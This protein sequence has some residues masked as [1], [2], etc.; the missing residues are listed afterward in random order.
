[1][2]EV[3]KLLL[4]EAEGLLGRLAEMRKKTNQL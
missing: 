3:G 4:V 1:M 2:T